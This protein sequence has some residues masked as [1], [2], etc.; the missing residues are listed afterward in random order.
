MLARQAT[1]I[2]KDL[3]ASSEPVLITEYGEPSAY[4]VNINDYEE[5]QRRLEILEGITSGETAIIRNRTLTQAE[6]EDKLNKWLK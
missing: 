2:L 3:N 4:L 6:A 1:K 5:T